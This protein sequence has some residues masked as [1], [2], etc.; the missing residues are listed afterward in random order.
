MSDS[1]NVA[2]VARKLNQDWQNGSTN[3]SASCRPSRDTEAARCLGNSRQD[4]GDEFQE[5]AEE[6]GLEDEDLE[7][8]NQVQLLAVNLRSSGDAGRGA[9]R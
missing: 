1:T 4:S 5:D 6:Q 3:S 7:A 8:R 9:R 2:R